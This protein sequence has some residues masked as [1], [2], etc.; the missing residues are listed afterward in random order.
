MVGDGVNDAPAL[1][2]ADLGIAMG[3]GSDVAIETAA[4]TLMR[5]ELLLVPA[6]LDI[7]ARTQAIVYQGLA[8]ALLYNVVAIPLA[9]AGRLTPLIAGVSMA[10]S[11]LS[12][13]LN[14]LRLNLWRPRAYTN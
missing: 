11:S 5:P 14:A 2:A 3:S 13:V 4:I 8:W 7:A 10:F 1:A 12:V 9:A 6:A